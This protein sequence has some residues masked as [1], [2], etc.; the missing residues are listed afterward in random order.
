MYLAAATCMYALRVWMLGKIDAERVSEELVKEGDG[1]G[2][3]VMRRWRRA[4]RFWRW[5]KV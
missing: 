1:A 2:R 3:G 5:A 4:G